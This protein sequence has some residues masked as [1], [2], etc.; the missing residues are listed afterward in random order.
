[1]GKRFRKRSRLA[2]YTTGT[3]DENARNEGARDI[4][5][6]AG[7]LRKE[8]DRSEARV[9]Y[10]RAQKTNDVLLTTRTSIELT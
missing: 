5:A 2:I 6:I 4:H 7:S 3:I 9:A 10:R 1:M 8:D